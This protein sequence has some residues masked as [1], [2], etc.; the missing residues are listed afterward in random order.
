M[1]GTQT[2]SL[3]EVAANRTVLKTSSEFWRLTAKLHV[4][5]PWPTISPKVPVTPF[6]CLYLDLHEIHNASVT[7]NPLTLVL[8]YLVSIATASMAGPALVGKFC[9]W[10]MQ[11]HGI[12][13]RDDA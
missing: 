3:L 9:V 7:T 1:L 2:T 11:P 5:A 8:A 13:T 6:L 12:F 10:Y 4:Q